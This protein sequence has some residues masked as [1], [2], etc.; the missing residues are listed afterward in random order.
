M[1]EQKTPKIIY[2]ITLANS[3]TNCHTYNLPQNLQAVRSFAEF[4]ALMI[5]NAMSREKGGFLFFQNP[6]TWYNPDYV[7][8][9]SFE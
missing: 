7:V 6:G 5:T 9:V 4:M 2:S 3:T 1:N 8:K